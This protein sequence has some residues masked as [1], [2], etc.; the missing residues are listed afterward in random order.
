LRKRLFIF[1]RAFLIVLL[2]TSNI[3]SI[4]KEYFLITIFISTG[5]STMWVLNIK[6]LAISDWYDRLCYIFGATIGTTISLYGIKLL[7]N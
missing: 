2:T 1:I 5:I 6:D 7:T 4:S 3:Y